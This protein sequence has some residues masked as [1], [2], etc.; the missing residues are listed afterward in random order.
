MNWS[1]AFSNFVH[2]TEQYLGPD[3]KGEVVHLYLV[4]MKTAQIEFEVAKT[5]H[6]R[7]KILRM[8]LNCLSPKPPSSTG[9]HKRFQRIQCLFIQ[10]SELPQ[11][12]LA[13]ADSNFKRMTAQW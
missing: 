5:Y 10:K 8:S 3:K 13:I 12:K 1:F 6:L 7:I 4:Q 9:K 11:K 2:F